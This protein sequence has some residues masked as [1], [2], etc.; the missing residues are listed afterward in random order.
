M[1]DTDTACESYFQNKIDSILITTSW[2]D[3]LKELL[4]VDAVSQIWGDVPSW[5]LWL[6]AAQ[7]VYKLQLSH[8]LETKGNPTCKQG[9][10]S[11][12]CYPQPNTPEFET[13]SYEEKALLRSP[14]F[15][16]TQTPCFENKERIPDHLFNVGVMEFR[17]HHDDSVACLTLESMDTLRWVYPE[18]TVVNFDLIHTQKRFEAGDIDR[19]VSGWRMAYPLF[20]RLLC[21]FAFYAKTKPV[22]LCVTRSPGF[23]YRFSG[24]H[25]FA[26]VNTP[27]IHRLTASVY[28]ASPGGC[29]GK[30]AILQ[31]FF[32][33]QEQQEEGETLLDCTYPCGHVHMTEKRAPVLEGAT[34]NPLWWSLSETEYSSS[35]TSTCGCH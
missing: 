32:A 1:V 16:D 3:S 22:R 25:T 13:Y 18:E 35:L 14:F 34:V 33:Q 28:F 20:D 23:E 11:I 17:A 7:G 4:G 27:D 21:M 30:D 19:A 31:T 10:F 8:A 15:D 24:D 2:V 9:L 26:C 12:N 5:Y 6:N 29:C